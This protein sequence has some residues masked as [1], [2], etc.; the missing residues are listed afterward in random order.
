MVLSLLIKNSPTI[1]KLDL[2][3][4]YLIF[5][6]TKIY[7]ENMRRQRKPLTATSVTPV[8]LLQEKKSTTKPIPSTAQRKVTVFSKEATPLP[9][10][11]AVRL[12]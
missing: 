5:K 7:Y 3:Y 6:T 9:S 12:S 8:Y 4:I 1:I 10:R 2:T 11:P